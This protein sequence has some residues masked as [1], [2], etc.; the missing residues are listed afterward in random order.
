MPTFLVF[1]LEKN[2]DAV[3]NFGSLTREKP[4][5]SEIKELFVQK[6]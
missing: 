6:H 1:L 3:A 2:L 5:P 4:A